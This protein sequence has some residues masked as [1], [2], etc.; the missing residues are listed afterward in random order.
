MNRYIVTIGEFGEDFEY[1]VVTAVTKSDAAD[2][3]RQ[4]AFDNERED[5][6]TTIDIKPFDESA[7]IVHINPV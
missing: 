4:W 1:L 7:I 3:A 6:L 5:L 2:I